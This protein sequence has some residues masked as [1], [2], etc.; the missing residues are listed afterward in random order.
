MKYSKLVLIGNVSFLTAGQ[1]K[2][3]RALLPRAYF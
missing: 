1:G 2:F 3:N